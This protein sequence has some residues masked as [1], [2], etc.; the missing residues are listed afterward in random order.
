VKIQP[1]HCVTLIAQVKVPT[2]WVELARSVFQ[3]CVRV[4]VRYKTVGIL[5]LKGCTCI[6]T[7]FLLAQLCRSS[8]TSV[9]RLEP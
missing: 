7:A 3:S 6:V 8:Q 5:W 4:S 2:E 9:W 1:R